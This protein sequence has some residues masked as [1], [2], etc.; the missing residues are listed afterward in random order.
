PATMP[1]P[2]GAMPQTSPAPVP[3]FIEPPPQTVSAPTNEANVA[4]F[5]NW[6]K[7]NQLNLMAKQPQLAHSSKIPPPPLRKKIPPRPKVRLQ[8]GL[9]APLVQSPPMSYE[10]SQKVMMDSA[11]PA[12]A[13]SPDSVVAFDGMV[14]QNMPLSPQQVVKLRQ[15]VDTSQRAAAIQP[16][17]PPK[18]VS[19][20]LMINLAP[21]ATPPAIRLAQG[22]V[23]SLVFVDSTGAPWPIASYDIGDPKSI[24]HQWD[25]KSNILLIQAIA[26]YSNGNIVIRLVGLPT[27]ITLE[28]V[29]GQRVVDYRTDIHVSGIGPN[30]KEIPIGTPLPAS[31]NQLLL[32][33]L[34]GVSPPGSKQMMVKGGDA[35]AWVL[36]D[37][38]YIRTR[39]TVLSPGW[40]GK[41]VSPDGMIAYEM[42]QTSSVLI[43]QY[44]NPIELKIE[45]F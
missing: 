10:E 39:F 43:S 35:Q 25:G 17:V 11:P 24:N 15:L 8:H 2:S 3:S 19:S 9:N 33:I 14:Q 20:T 27:P 26:P 5:Q 18:P 42:Q 30:S 38:M 12:P 1:A 29:S 28:I 37:K 22:Y 6:L 44:G 21:G 31:A 7:N 32:S 4:Q 13:P 36:G 16:N 23:S 45:G 34:D 40:I 41:M